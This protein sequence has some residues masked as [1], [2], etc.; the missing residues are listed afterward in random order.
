MF[1]VRWDKENN[2]FIISNKIKDKDKIIP[3]RPVFFEELELLGFGDYW[4]YPKTKKPLLWAIGRRYFYKGTM[5]AEAK[6]G[7]IYEKPILQVEHKGTLEP[8]NVDTLISKNLEFLKILEGEAIDFIQEIFKIYKKKN[9]NFAV[10]FSGGKDS[11]VV[12]DLVSRVI[13]PDEYITVF[14]D[15]GMEIPFNQKTIDYT[16]EKYSKQY[17]GFRFHTAKADKDVLFYWEKFGP[18]SRIHRWC[19]SVCK[20][21]P[22]VQKIQEFSNSKKENRIVVFEGVRAEESS[23][24]SKYQRITGKG[25]KAKQINAEIILDWNV[26]EVFLYLFYRKILVN[27][28]YRFGLTRVGCSI[29][30]FSSPW[31]EFIMQNIA[32]ETT[33]K[34]VSIIK[35]NAL[36][37]SNDKQ[38]IDEF[39]KSGQW[40]VRSGGR[41]LIISS[42]LSAKKNNINEITYSI[43]NPQE[44]VLEWLKILGQIK[45]IVEDN[46]I[47]GEIKSDENVILFIL[48]KSDKNLNIQFKF[49]GKKIIENRINKIIHKSAFCVQCRACQV[50][51]PVE[52]ISFNPKLRIDSKLCI[53]CFKCITFADKGCLR[54]KSINVT[55]GGLRMSDN[56]VA[57]SKYQTFGLRNHWLK[58]FLN[59]P[60][61]WFIDNPAGLGNR[62]VQAMVSWLKDAEILTSKKE[63][64]HFGN[65][66][67]NFRNNEIRIWTLIWTNL[68]SKVNLIKWYLNDIKWGEKYS[69]KELVE[70]IVDKDSI[71][72]P[73]TT[74][75]AI[76]SL[77]NM[78]A[79]SPLSGILSIGKITKKSNVRTIWKTG[80]DEI[81]SLVVAYSLYKYA[82]QKER[83]K[84]TVSEFYDKN[85]DGGPFILFG[86]SKEKFETILRG[87]QEEKNQLVR[88]NLVAGLDNIFLREDVT[89]LEVLEILD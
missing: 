20:T 68:H 3:P 54:A 46:Q 73:K 25:K 81:D 50:E 89:P 57:T 86:L 58:S 80:S 76:S 64:T 72:K 8:I 9:L 18:P 23:R 19:C 85:C 7:N 43:E 40:K 42:S 35:K 5:V 87:L 38:V 79:E 77:V 70:M 47:R 74:Q 33:Q 37:E 29:C 49:S 56:K 82:E 60:E 17:P 52:A 24:R 15:T 62:Q 69:T 14:T 48:N 11:Q 22:F 51:C 65:S 4:E 34:F 1:K 63:L 88:V 13:S 61:N 21:V 55:E 59:K 26:A 44:N 78:F 28:G 6:G 27:D 45:Y 12:L 67:V 2:G 75:N 41:N 39:I 10:A 31:S 71:N 83:Y 84:F 30:P 53:H 66:L 36:N 32:K 16:K